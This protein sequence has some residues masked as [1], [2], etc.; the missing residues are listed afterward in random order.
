MRTS[1][2]GGPG[3]TPPEKNS[4]HRCDHLAMPVV[5]SAV[6]GGYQAVCLG[7]KTAGRY[8]KGPG[9]RSWDSSRTVLTT[10]KLDQPGRG[11]SLGLGLFSLSE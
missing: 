2:K 6:P 11:P 9:L 4:A 7:C 10:D 3:S 1:Q 8:A 5:A